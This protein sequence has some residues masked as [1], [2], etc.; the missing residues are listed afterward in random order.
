[1]GEYGMVTNNYHTEAIACSRL[2]LIVRLQSGSMPPISSPQRSL[3]GI[4]LLNLP[5]VDYGSNPGL[6]HIVPRGGKD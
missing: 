5:M 3:A 4:E 1:M 2:V 6:N